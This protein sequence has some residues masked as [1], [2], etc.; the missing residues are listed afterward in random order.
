MLAE[1]PVV[2][3]LASAAGAGGVA[4]EQVQEVL[5]GCPLQHLPHPDGHKR[6]VLVIH[7]IG[8]QGLVP[9]A[10]LAEGIVLV[11]LPRQL[12]HVQL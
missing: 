2:A 5:G 1:V 7:G 3:H 8:L 9:H 11:G 4:L 12:F 10:I 6:V